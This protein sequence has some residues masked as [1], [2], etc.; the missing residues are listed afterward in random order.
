LET[1]LISGGFY[2]TQIIPRPPFLGDL[3][4]PDRMITLTDCLTEFLGDWWGLE[5]ASCSNAERIAAV[6]KLGLPEEAL[7]TLLRTTTDAFSRGELG[8]S[9]VWQSSMA[10]RTS[11]APFK[12]LPVE[13][14]VLELGVPQDLVAKLLAG[15]IRGKKWDESGFLTKLKSAIPLEA[16]STPLG[17]EVLGVDFGGSFHSWLCNHLHNHASDKL[18]IRPGP[19][20][21]L[22]SEADARAIVDEIDSGLPAEPV[23]WFPGLITRID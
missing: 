18:N 7:P 14:V 8:W 3:L 4:L 23:P 21:L 6:R 11:L 15:L 12:T 16:E 19:L 17:W 10:A 2:V 1:S 22:A 9:R 20:G 5:W 13:W